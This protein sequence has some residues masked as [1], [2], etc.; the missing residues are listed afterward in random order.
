MA[1]PDGIRIVLTRAGDRVLRADIGSTR[2][3]VADRLFSGKAP[4]D[5]LP[6][7]ALLFSL[8]GTAQAVAGLGAVEQAAS[9]PAPAAHDDARALLVLA[10]LVA[11]HGLALARDWPILAGQ[12]PRLDAA[13][14]M[15]TAQRALVAALYPD[16]DWL[17]IGGGR[18]APDHAALTARLAAMRAA[19]DAAVD[20][21]VAALATADGFNRWLDG[22]GALSL[23]GFVAGH[24]WQALGAVPF[25]PLPADGPDDLADRLAADTDGHFLNRPD[26]RGEHGETGPLARHHR[27]PLV[28]A[29]LATHGAGLLTRLAARLVAVANALD[30]LDHLAATL[31]PGAGAG[32]GLADG[33][34]LA[35][36]QTARGLL[37]H[38]VELAGGRIARYQILAPTEW[39]FHPDGPL[40]AALTGLAVDDTL[41]LRARLLV[42]AFDP[43]VTCTVDMGEVHA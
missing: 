23:P 9:R 17:T 18:L 33:A 15:R 35:T 32:G 27:H 31:P 40:A 36:V 7:V 39:N 28:A 13:K 26:W 2:L 41:D 24:G 1:V 12:P 16:G 42:Q 29:L 38:R 10:E 5:I 22:A 37:V 3:A 19:I 14:A 6:M 30:H 34:G 20:H 4:A 25:A 8:C 21:P 43:C 11:E